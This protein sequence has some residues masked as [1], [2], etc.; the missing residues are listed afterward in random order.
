VEGV[1]LGIEAVHLGMEAIRLDPSRAVVP[2]LPVA[3]QIGFAHAV[4][5]GPTRSELQEWK[6][7]TSEVDSDPTSISRPTVARVASLAARAVAVIH[8]DRARSNPPRSVPLCGA[9]IT[10]C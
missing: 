3:G 6:E 9:A 7:E 5:T 4:A 8:L 2:P 10:L 1:R